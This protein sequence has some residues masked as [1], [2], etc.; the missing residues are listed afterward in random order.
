MWFAF[1]RQQLAGVLPYRVRFFGLAR[2]FG[3]DAS[4]T[5]ETVRTKSFDV[6]D[7]YE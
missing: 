2:V 5:I 6:S 1:F 3:G 4:D 7:G